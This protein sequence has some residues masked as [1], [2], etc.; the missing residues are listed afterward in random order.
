MSPRPFAGALCLAARTFA[1]ESF[2][3][4]SGLNR[5]SNLISP[6]S[7]RSLRFG[8]FPRGLP[9]Q[10]RNPGGSPLGGSGTRVPCSRTF[11]SR[12]PKPRFRPAA[13]S[14]AEALVPPG[15]PL[16]RDPLACLVRSSRAETRSCTT[17]WP[18]QFAGGFA[19]TFVPLKPGRPRICI[20]HLPVDFLRTGGP[21]QP[22]GAGR[23]YAAFASAKGQAR[24]FRLAAAS[25]AALPSLP[26]PSP[27]EARACGCSG[28][29]WEG[30]LSVAGKIV[31]ATDGSC[32]QK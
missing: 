12:K 26:R 30:S 9:A 22:V 2:E 14:L 25:S 27:G 29:G 1:P 20:R 13:G 18:G 17:I 19:L 3:R 21:D 4:R 32:H 28:R 16:D 23:S 24:S 6:G 15:R 10:G 7:S 31:W 11:R 5:S 8:Q